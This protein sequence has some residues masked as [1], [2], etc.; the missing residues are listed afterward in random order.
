M[1]KGP[2]NRGEPIC[3]H[4]F[5]DRGKVCSDSKQCH[6]QCRYADASLFADPGTEGTVLFK[7]ELSRNLPSNDQIGKPGSGYCQWSDDDRSGCNGAVK[8]GRI[9]EWICVD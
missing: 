2:L 8:D 6:G 3:V 5:S 1:I 7:N 4:F 9:Q